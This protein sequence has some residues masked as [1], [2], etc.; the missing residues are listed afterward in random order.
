M[1]ELLQLS[2]FADGVPVALTDG[3]VVGVLVL[4]EAY[5]TYGVRNVSLVELVHRCLLVVPLEC[6]VSPRALSAWGRSTLLTGVGVLAEV[7]L[8]EFDGERTYDDLV[9]LVPAALFVLVGLY[10]S[11]AAGR[12]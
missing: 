2:S 11:V 5:P 8:G 12:G 9:W 3:G 4:P 1:R 10:L 6:A 7:P